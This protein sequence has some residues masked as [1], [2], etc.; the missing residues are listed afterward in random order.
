MV[1]IPCEFVC[2]REE[3]NMVSGERDFAVVQVATLLSALAVF[4]SMGM[5]RIRQVVKRTFKEAIFIL[6]LTFIF[7]WEVLNVLAVRTCFYFLHF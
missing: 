7:C 6:S 1:G 4:S 2:V 3:G 5:S